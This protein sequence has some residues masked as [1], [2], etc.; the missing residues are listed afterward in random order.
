MRN[1]KIN[2]LI[3]VI[4][5]FCFFL[6]PLSVLAIGQVSKPIVIENALKGEEYEDTLT[7][8]NSSDHEETFGLSAKGEITEWSKFYSLDDLET[9][10]ETIKIPANSKAKAKVIFFIPLDTPN[11][12]YKGEIIV[13][14]LSK[15]K[16]GNEK[17]STLVTQ[18][19]P[20]KVIITVTGEQILSCDALI[21]TRKQNLE[22][23]EPL[24]TEVSFF[25][26]GNARIKPTIQQKITKDGKIIFN[27]I[28]PYPESDEGIKPKHSK[29][30]P[31]EWQTAGQKSGA[32][33]AEIKA[34]LDNEVVKENDFHFSVGIIDGANINNIL[35]YI[36]RL[37]GG[38]LVLG[39]FIIGGFF[40]MLSM[41]LTF[42]GRKK[43]FW[44]RLRRR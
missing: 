22:K 23:D 7:M 15:N 16:E 14:L 43:G 34:L 3:P 26:T 4:L 30:L 24:K 32:Y 36:S 40:I 21:I 19:I 6:S 9:P 18:Q 8:Y 5:F 31:V 11:E 25:N 42:A 29:I 33:R 20:R 28:Y 37:G 10:I 1:I 38:N 2:N 35:N 39:W 17:I 41:M 27:A 12:L 44:E 13:S